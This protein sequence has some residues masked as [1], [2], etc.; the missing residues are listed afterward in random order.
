ML[1]HALARGAL[2]STAWLLAWGPGWDASAQTLGTFA[3]Q[4]APYCNVV[5][6][7][8]AVDGQAF[9]LTGFDD[10]CGGARLPAAG[11][12][13]PRGNGTYALTFY[14]VT[15]TGL[16]GHLTAALDPGSISGPWTDS[17]GAT[18]TLLFNPALP[19]SGGHRPAPRLPAIALASNSVTST[20]IADGA[21]G[22]AELADGSV[23]A[24]KLQF[25]IVRAVGSNFTALQVTNSQGG[26]IRGES[27]SGAPA[28][29][30]FGAVGVTGQTTSGVGV[31]GF[32]TSGTA[33]VGTSSGAGAA[34]RGYAGSGAAG[35]FQSLQPGVTADV[36]V[37]QSAGT[38]D[39]IEASAGGQTRFRVTATGA[40]QGDG[41]YSSPAADVAEFIDTDDALTPGD[42][43]EIDIERDG[44][45][46]RAATASSTAVAGV[47]TTR[48]GVLLNTRD[49]RHDV[50]DGPALALA[51]RVPVKVSTE[52]GPIVRGDLLVASSTPGHAMRAS[53]PAVGPG[54]VIGKA[55]GSLA[56]GTGVI[57]M[58]V[59]LR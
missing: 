58:L 37:V 43:V 57:E 48:P 35:L 41:P 47:V 30:G 9:R 13:T 55:L 4:I 22:P 14:V 6:F 25:P 11:V 46:R 12:A 39:L 26:A 44:V 45:F 3:W 27:Q 1:A 59:M 40:V 53:D 50:G 15:P 18:G 31:A 21:V 56:A 7:T 36:L 38:G 28:I 52:N 34:I 19:A 2:M 33:V 49:H 20:Q 8:V 10:Q 54:T 24:A 17:G 16:V 42:V 32:S 51:G 29:A 5:R 23:T